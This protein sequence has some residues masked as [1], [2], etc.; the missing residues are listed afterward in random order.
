MI[1][2]KNKKVVLLVTTTFGLTSLLFTLLIISFI[3]KKFL[4]I[5]HE[6]KAKIKATIGTILILPLLFLQSSQSEELSNGIEVLRIMTI[7]IIWTLFYGLF[8]PNN[9]E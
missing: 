9:N 1:N 3:L 7:P 6:M 4:N 5:L 2:L 8:K